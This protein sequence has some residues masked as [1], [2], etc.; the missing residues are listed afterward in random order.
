ML[1]IGIVG[2][3][4]I[5]QKAYLPFMRQL[6]NIHWHL[7]TRNKDVREEVSNLFSNASV[8]ADVN[9]LA[10]VKLDGVFIHVAT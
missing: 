10:S 8:Y 7:S 5:S 6:P 4:G 2:L 3:G 9:D 1:E